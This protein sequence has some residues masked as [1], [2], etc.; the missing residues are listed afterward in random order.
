MLVRVVR[1]RFGTSQATLT[2]DAEV[3]APTTAAHPAYAEFLLDALTHS[4]G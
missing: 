3:T 2:E 1:T 4:D